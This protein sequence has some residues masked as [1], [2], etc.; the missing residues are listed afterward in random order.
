M[1]A[2]DAEL[3]FVGTRGGL[4]ALDRRTGTR[5]WRATLW[6]PNSKAWTDVVLANGRVCIADYHGAGCADART[7]QVLWSRR[8]DPRG[9]TGESA[10]DDFA[11]YVATDS[12]TVYALDP[13]TGDQI[14]ATN[15]APEARYLIRTFGTA[16]AG[17]TV[18]AAMVRWLTEQGG[19]VVGDLVAMDRKTGRVLFRYTSPGTRGGFQGKP[20]IAG[21]L[22]ILN[23]VYAHALVAVDRFTGQEVWRTE[24]NESGYIT[25]ERPPVL[26]GDTLFA[27]S[28]DTQI[29]AVDVRTGNRIWRAFANHGSLGSLSVCGSILLATD[30]GAGY[31]TAMDRAT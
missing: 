9:T 22:A 30:F 24:K 25:S 11:W 12:S 28:T 1:P 23:D 4:T 20:V 13:A 18:Y 27:A 5:K 21:R 14:W 31:V 17:D 10:L 15:A 19:S 16:V 7:G 29:Y 2:A 26:V 3:V 6:D 8:V